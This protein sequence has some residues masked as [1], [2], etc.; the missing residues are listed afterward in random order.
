MASDTTLMASSWPTT[1]S[2]SLSSIFSSLSRSPCI[3]LA[4]GMPVARATTSAISSAPTCVRSSRLLPPA[5]ALPASAACA[6]ASFFS[7]SGS[8]PYCSSAT[9]L[10]SPVRLSFSIWK[11]SLSISSLR[12]AEPCAAAFSA[13]QISSRSAYSRPRRTISSSMRPMRRCEASSVS[14]RTASRSIF[15]WMMRRSSLSITS[16]LESISIFTFA[17]ASS[18]RSMALSG[19]K[20]SVM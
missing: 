15:S 18:I 20:R 5:V 17:A 10:K 8:L 11:R 19:R 1:R 13:V 4:T 3:S 7:R 16:G 12:A 2:C 9:L 6:S 14:R